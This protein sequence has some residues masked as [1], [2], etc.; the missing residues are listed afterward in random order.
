MK[1]RGMSQE[2]ERTDKEGE[3]SLHDLVMQ[4]LDA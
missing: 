4:T 3:A 2:K 1:E